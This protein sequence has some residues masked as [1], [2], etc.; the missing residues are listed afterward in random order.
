MAVSRSC[1]RP[2]VGEN[3]PPGPDGICA[4]VPQVS[5]APPHKPVESFFN[6]H[7]K[8]PSLL[9]PEEPTPYESVDFNQEQ[10][11]S[12]AEFDQPSQMTGRN[13]LYRS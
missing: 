6:R 1:I 3:L 8:T 10:I 7:G 12:N 4:L 5:R 11:E 9:A 13:L 2:L